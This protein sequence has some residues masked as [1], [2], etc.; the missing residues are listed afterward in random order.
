MIVRVF[1]YANC[2]T[3]RKALKFLAERKIAHEV[4]PIREQPPTVGELRA[5][6][7]H[8]GGDLRRLFNTSGRDYKELNM[9]ERLP[10]LSTEE[11]LALLAGNGN[12]VKRPFALT[13][14]AGVVGFKPEE[15]KRF[16]AAL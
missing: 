1:A 7:G 16:P 3:C 14:S 6:L 5:M 11:A 2:D 13:A 10:K 8:V 15:W 4:V 12:L 9:K